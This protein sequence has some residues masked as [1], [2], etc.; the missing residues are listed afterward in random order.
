MS[1]VHTTIDSPVGPL[2]LA[3][4][5]AG[6]HA[7]EFS[8]SRHPVPRGGRLARGRPPAA[9]RS[10]AATG[11]VLRGARRT[12]DLPLAPEGTG[13]QREVWRALAT[14]PY[15]ETSATRSWPRASAAEGDRARSAPPTAAI[16]CRSC[17]P[18]TA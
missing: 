9:A 5:D 3:A 12:F 11:R 13:F 1:I 16:R 14:I 2:L 6:L 10:P 17:C 15:G 8:R 4:S 7:I 18:A